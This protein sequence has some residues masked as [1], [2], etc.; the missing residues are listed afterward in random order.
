MRLSAQIIREWFANRTP[1]FCL[2]GS[3]YVLGGLDVASLARMT[4]VHRAASVLIV[5]YVVGSATEASAFRC[6]RTSSSC[7]VNLHWEQRTIPFVVRVPPA[8]SNID[9]ELLAVHTKAAFEAWSSPRCTDIRF[10]YRGEVPAGVESSV[11]NEIVVVTRDWNKKDSQS[12]ISAHQ[13]AVTTVSHNVVTGEIVGAKI[14][15]NEAI[16]ENSIEPRNQF[17]DF[18]EGLTETCIAERSSSGVYDLQ[19]VL[20]HELGHVLGIDH[21]CEYELGRGCE[22]NILCD[23]HLAEAGQEGLFLPVMWPE[24]LSCETKARTL[25]PSDIEAVCFIYPARGKARTCEALPNQAEP[26]VQNVAFGCSAAGMSNDRLIEL[27]ATLVASRVAARRRNYLALIVFCLR[28][29]R[30]SGLKAFEI[31]RAR[32]PP[33]G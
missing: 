32:K 11:A 2:L 22:P 9:A 4:T 5:C 30:Q 13:V 21:P 18:D 31:P 15:I 23:N 10:E 7:F 27:L 19:S 20:V 14:Y 33:F 6:S 28:T 17:I 26:Y 8:D 25:T 3:T 24:I 16:P 1:S 12:P 29:M